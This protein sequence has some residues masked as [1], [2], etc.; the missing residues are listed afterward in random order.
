M[1]FT[2]NAYLEDFSNG[3]KEDTNYV[4]DLIDVL[5]KN[6]TKRIMLADTLGVFSINEVNEYVSKITKKFKEAHFDFHAHNDYGLATANCLMAINC[7]VKGVHC[8]VNGLGERTGNAALEE[9]VSA[10]NDFTEFKTKVNEEKLQSISRLVELF[11]RNRVSKN[12]PIVGAS[13]FTQTAG[14]HADGDKKGNLYIS[15]LSPKRFGRTTRYALGKLSGKSSIVLTLRS[16]GIVLED[17]QLNEVLKR[18]ISLGDKKEYVTKEDLLFIVDEV[19][20]NLKNKEFEILDY[21]ISVGKSKKPFAK[22]KVFFKSKEYSFSSFGS[23]GFD[24]FISALKKLFKKNKL[25]FPKLEDY[26]V[27]IPIGGRT[28]ALVE[29]K[30]IWKKGNR[31]LETIGVSTD[32]TEAGIKATEKMVNLILKLK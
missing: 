26:E 25:S 23:G 22:I 2:V 21:N 12:K 31:T 28:D 29:T 30:I 20:H 14:I 16:Y 8:T 27:R 32:Q 15:K 4:E 1:N 13:V 18:V 10:V 19:E 24:A 5:I 17:K 3:V 11:S 6:N 7:G 9:V